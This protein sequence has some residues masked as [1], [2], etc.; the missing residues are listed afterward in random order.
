[1]IDGDKAS[2]L[3]AE[4]ENLTASQR[5]PPQ[6]TKEAAERTRQRLARM[7]QDIAAGA[8]ELSL[9]PK[10][11]PNLQGQLKQKVDAAAAWIASQTMI[12]FSG[13]LAAWTQQS[14]SA[15]VPRAG[16]TATALAARLTAASRAKALR[17][18]ADP[19]RHKTSGCCNKAL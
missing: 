7:E 15:A 11:T 2:A 14:T 1:M 18:D 4:I 19:V 3:L 6:A 8:R 13:V 9:D 12:D 17:F 16:A 5:V 10:L